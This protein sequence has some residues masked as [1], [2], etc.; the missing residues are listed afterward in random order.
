MRIQM[1]DSETPTG[2]S[3]WVHGSRSTKSVRPA[4]DDCGGMMTLLFQDNI[5]YCTTLAREGR[6]QP[7]GG[8]RLKP[9]LFSR[10]GD[11][12]LQTVMVANVWT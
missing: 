6:A 1:T 10:F 12:A 3:W 11:M 5:H 4:W 8:T 2:Y 7:V 9:S